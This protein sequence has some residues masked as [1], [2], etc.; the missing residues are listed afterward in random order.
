MIDAIGADQVVR[1]LES[2]VIAHGPRF[3]PCDALR[4]MAES[5]AKYY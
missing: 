1:T 5:G 3:E 2:L 4:E